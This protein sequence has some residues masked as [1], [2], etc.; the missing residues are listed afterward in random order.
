METIFE[1]VGA[2]DVQKAQVTV[3]VRVPGAAELR[4]PHLAE[5]STMVQG[6]MALRDWLGDDDHPGDV[7]FKDPRD[8][9]RVAVTSNATQ[10]RSSRL[11]ANNSSAAGR[12][13]I[14][15][16]D[17]SRPSATIATS[18]KSRW[19]SSA[20]ALTHSSSPSIDVGRTGGQTTSTDP[21]SQ[22]NQASRRGGH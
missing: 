15:P 22:R 5:F 12:V 21:R 11:R 1:R 13:S 17:R 10:S 20:T 14:R 3:C 9:P 7:R 6:L 2:L 8:R 16:A 18:Q 19:T 4:E